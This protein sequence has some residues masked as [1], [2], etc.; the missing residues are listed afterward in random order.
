MLLIPA[1][2]VSGAGY[3]QVQFKVTDA[4]TGAVLSDVPLMVTSDKVYQVSTDIEGLTNSVNVKKDQ[5][6]YV[7][8]DFV[9]EGYTKYSGDFQANQNNKT[10]VIPLEL[11]QASLADKDYEFS[12]V[13]RTTGQSVT[14]NGKATFRC[15]NGVGLPP[16]PVDILNGKIKV[17]ADPNCS[18]L[19]T[20]IADGYNPKYDT[21]VTNGTISVYL[22]PTTGS[23]EGGT[24]TVTVYTKGTTGEAL[25]NIKVVAYNDIGVEVASCIT[26]T[27]GNCILENVATGDYTLRLT[28]NRSVPLYSNYTEALYV[29]SNTT[30]YIDMTTQVSGY[31][32]I[33]VVDKTTNNP[34]KDAYVA[35]KVADKI[36]SDSY[37]DVA[38][39]KLFTVAD[40]T[41]NYRV[42]VDANGYMIKSTA[43]TVS[44]TVPS[45]PTK[46][47]LELVTPQTIAK[48]NIRVLDEL[49]R[50]YRFAKV[51]LYDADTGFLTDYRPL[52]TDYD[53]NV[54]FHI[55]SGKYYAVAIKGA[56][57][58]D[59]AVFE[60]DVRQAD[61][62]DT[63][64]IP[65]NITK[66]TLVIKVVDKEGVIVPNARVTIYDRYSYFGFNPP[67]AIKSDL[68]SALGEISFELDA[69]N[70]YFAVV[71][72][73]INENLGTA[74]SKFIRVAPNGTKELK[75][76]LYDK[77]S[78]L[79]KPE[80]KLSGLYKDDLLVSGN[81]KPG[82]EY[83]ARFTLF[84]PQDRSG[85]DRFQ[86]V[87]TIIRTGNTVYL[88]NDNLYIK[89]IDV[90]N[91][92]SIQKFTQFDMVNHKVDGIYDSDTLTDG[93]SKW[94]KVVFEKP[95]YVLGEEYPNTY[96][97]VATIK[98]RDSAAFG[99][100]LKLFYL[101]YGL[102]RDDDYE[103]YNPYT[104]S[105][106]DIEYFDVY[107][108]QTYGI[109]DEVLCSDDFC[110][111]ANMVDVSANLRY[112]VSTNF[113][114][115][116]NKNYK[117]HFTLINNQQDKRYINSRLLIEN[118]DEG[119]N[120]KNIKIDS[121]NG[122]QIT[123]N[124]PSN[125]Y[126]F[127][128]AISSL[129]A[130]QKVEGDIN[131]TTELIGDRH[132]VIKFISD[133]KILF[134][135]D[136]V[137]TVTSNKEF[138][139]DITPEVIPSNKSF[140]LQ[141]EARDSLTNV[142]VKDSYVVVKDRFFDVL[143]T[144]PMGVLGEVSIN[145][146]PGQN[147]GDSIYVYVSAPEYKT[148][149]KEIKISDTL[150]SI[151]P[152]RLGF[153]LNINNERTK[154]ES[155]TITNSSELDL[156]VADLVIKGENLNIIDI[157]R[158]N[159][160]LA[161]YIGLVI[162]G[163]DTSS[164]TPD[165]SDAT[166]VIEMRLSVNPRAEGITEVQNMKAK[167]KVSLQAKGGASP[168]WVV[169]IP[170]AITVGFD[171]VMDNAACLTLTETA[172]KDVSL[173]KPVE[174]QFIVNNRC[175]MNGK[176]VPLTG[177]LEV[178]IQYDSS[179]LGKFSANVNNRLLEL[180]SGYYKT[181]VDSMDRDAGYPVVLRY[182][183]TG[184]MQGNI[185]GKIIFRS[186]NP[187]TEGNQEL[188]AEYAFDISVL[189]LEDCY[190]VSKKVLNLYKE[191]DTFTI[192]N[193]GCGKDT[194]Y[195]LSCDDCRGIVI[196]PR[197]EI[198]V[199]ETGSSG[200][201]T[202]TSK[203]AIPG[204]YLINI[205]SKIKDARGSEIN[206]GQVKVQVRP[207]D[208][209][210]DLDRYEFDLYR[211]NVSENTG[212]AVNA[213]SYDTANII[214]TC[215]QQEIT[216]SGK[217]KDSSR[218]GM[219]LIAALRDGVYTWAGSSLVQWLG[220]KEADSN[221]S[222]WEIAIGKK[223]AKCS[224]PADK[225]ISSEDSSLLTAQEEFNQASSDLAS[226]DC[227]NIANKA[228]CDELNAKKVAAQEKINQ[229]NANLTEYQRL[230]K[231]YNAQCYDS[232]TNTIRNT[233]ECK[234]LVTQIQTLGPDPEGPG[235]KFTCE[236]VTCIDGQT[237]NPEN[238]NCE[239]NAISSQANNTTTDLCA[240]VT[241][242]EGESCDASTGECS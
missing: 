94:A 240:N 138:I 230:N 67:I 235:V 199:P 69:E 195:R 118:E 64:I 16:S 59:S 162:K 129:D 143:R 183:P 237:C 56:S 216:G 77:V 171:G 68:T 31:I 89:S 9:D 43:V 91:A 114:A 228:K 148:Y 174:K 231:Q 88:E 109:G 194:T 45:T 79:S 223:G 72:D 165:N 167:L 227:T 182:E 106:S 158:L 154:T 207:L 103:T 177:G 175:T 233:K 210:L 150:F 12:I 152:K 241:C 58:G 187:T 133:Q 71:T 180:S 229:E 179:P 37:T 97:I 197:T 65:M 208:S 105:Q 70:D 2:F 214:N 192:D 239:D 1:I 135:Q 53:G 144:E 63:I 238:G 184:R 142:E 115:D 172:W 236:G 155:F 221:C 86:E 189:S 110:Y 82:S 51:A 108:L 104:G 28:D 121:P 42:V 119:I 178:K 20:I 226:L 60:F 99:E 36:I 98:V 232:K 25:S 212:D 90:P 22:D 81:L 193:K 17:S 173:G 96:E 225:S 234:D 5:T 164:N 163:I 153:S 41:L 166:K 203:D 127:D 137:V 205:Y 219:A 160:E 218:L 159:N 19:A 92:V 3:Y 176:T 4:I 157:D 85:N 93:D 156:E 213:K 74:Q 220:K 52:L 186:M 18:L 130:K 6:F 146:L 145:N 136:L 73:L 126:S 123:S 124:I 48:L 15:M 55:T 34:I 198:D 161:G 54:T 30:K 24:Y 76:V 78:S 10:F 113:S 242:A 38:G 204:Q 21:P 87:G 132:I 39:E 57:R 26:N 49:G 131:F 7:D 35:L 206:V 29:E 61:T 215:Y 95:N 107:S 168:T 151:T 125:E 169:E 83:E 190:V 13:N 116:P 191:P 40:K 14:A 112:D 50:G 122:S 33:L 44:D 188:I 46:I 80:L 100:E 149:V 32:K 211:R 117:L 75:V 84:V 181:V 120:F 141:V 27:G 209:C 11:L 139:T 101:G 217:I 62:Y 128:Y 147:A 134:V 196:E 202:V 222:L 224:A 66:G 200:T 111:S 8:I 47:K 201:I 185:K 140:S 102:N 170:V 23:F